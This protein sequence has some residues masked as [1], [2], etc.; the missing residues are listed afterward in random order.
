MRDTDDDRAAF[1]EVLAALGAVFGEEITTAR[2]AL[3]FRALSD[4]PIAV[5]RAAAEGAMR[6]CRYFPR[7]IELRELA[8]H[9]AP[10]AGLIEAH[11]VA[12]LRRPEYPPRN[13]THPFLRLVMER[14]GGVYQVAGMTSLERLQALKTIVPCLIPAAIAR[15]IPLL[16]QDSDPIAIALMARAGDAVLPQPDETPTRDN[17]PAILDRILRFKRP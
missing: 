16:T 1:A 12:H 6:G 15:G 13:P 4:L 3:Y 17:A 8:G 7:P 14:L 11:I 9:G 5:V 10:D 2:V